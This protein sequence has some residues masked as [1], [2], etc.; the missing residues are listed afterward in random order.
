ME[1]GNSPSRGIL[2]EQVVPGLKEQ[3]G[4]AGLTASADKAAGRVGVI[5]LW[6]TEAD[7]EAS[8]SAVSKLRGSATEAMGGRLAGVESY[9][10]VMMEA[11]GPPAGPGSPVVIVRSKRD[12]ARVEERRGKAR[13]GDRRALRV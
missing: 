8:S 13:R 1:N 9:E 10:Q 5:S 7:L 4:F 3:K 2:A 11:T 6:Q 12:P